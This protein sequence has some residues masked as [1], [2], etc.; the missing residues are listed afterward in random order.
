MLNLLG[1]LSTKDI[2]TPDLLTKKNLFTF[3]YKTRDM[4]TFYG[5]IQIKN[6]G[7]PF[8][9]QVQASSPSAATKIVEAQY[10]KENIIW[11]RHMASK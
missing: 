9:V 4:Q 10:G 5:K 7:Q 2:K 11:K 6:G 8:D 1:F 3:V